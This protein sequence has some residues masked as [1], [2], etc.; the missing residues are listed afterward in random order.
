MLT[1]WHIPASTDP[2]AYALDV[3]GN[4]LGSGRTSRLYKALV[5]TG[6]C[7]QASAWSSAFGYVDPFLF[8]T[9][10]AMSP[11]VDPAEVEPVI[12]DA[13]R[14]VVKDGVTQAE[15]ERAKKQARVSFVYN[16]DSV[17]QE[18]DALVTFELAGSWRGSTSTCRGSRP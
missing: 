18:A 9:M 1:G 6:K 10:A 17:E 14:R 2:D 16:K 3:L 4:I 5:D 11:G 12:Y 13:D 8:M 7:A 15:L